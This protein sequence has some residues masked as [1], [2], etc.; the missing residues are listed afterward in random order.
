MDA[1]LG[2]CGLFCEYF[3]YLSTSQGRRMRPPTDPLRMKPR[4]PKFLVWQHFDN[5]WMANMSSACCAGPK[6]KTRGTR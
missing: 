6:T 2:L 3:T 1:L 4:C 5:A